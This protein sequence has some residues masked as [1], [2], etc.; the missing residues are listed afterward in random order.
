VLSKIESIRFVLF[1]ERDVV[2]HPLVQSVIT[3]YEALDRERE[4]A[5]Q[6]ASA[7]PSG[8]ASGAARPDRRPA[9]PPAVSR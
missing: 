9:A 2:R 4:A 8:P 1:D 3:A 7:R 6:A 5:A